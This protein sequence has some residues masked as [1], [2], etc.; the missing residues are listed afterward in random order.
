M[1]GVAR[2]PKIG[3]P[4]LRLVVETIG[5][6]C[7]VCNRDRESCSRDI[8]GVRGG[9]NRIL[10]EIRPIQS[11]LPKGTCNGHTARI[12]VV[13]RRNLRVRT[14]AGF[15]DPWLRFDG[16]G[17]GRPGIRDRNDRRNCRV[18]QP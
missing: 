2:R 1:P 14:I 15:N 7:D 9:G 13:A 16:Y 8:I 5:T 6:R 4:E 18:R 12:R 17:G 11:R 10:E 3:H